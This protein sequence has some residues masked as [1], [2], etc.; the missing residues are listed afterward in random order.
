[1]CDI[2]WYFWCLC[3]NLDGEFWYY[4]WFCPRSAFSMVNLGDIPKLSCWGRF[5][6]SHCQCVGLLG[7]Y[8][9]SWY[10]LPLRWQ[11]QQCGRV[12]N[13]F[14]FM[15]FSKCHI[16][17]RFWCFVLICHWKKR[18][19]SEIS[20]WVLIVCLFCPVPI[21]HSQILKSVTHL[22][23]CQTMPHIVFSH[24]MPK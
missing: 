19:S 11:T 16:L 9:W 5:R 13:L 1:M 6:V 18:S 2:R 20:V 17:L 22:A 15:V 4:G 23:S 3:G 8:S 10:F 24:L 21:C 12:V 7:L 14:N